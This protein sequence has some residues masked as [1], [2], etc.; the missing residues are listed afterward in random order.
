MLVTVGLL[1]TRV[2]RARR[3]AQP[4]HI[5]E[6]LGGAPDWQQLVLRQ[7]HCVRLDRGAVLHR[8]GRTVGKPA[9]MHLAAGTARFEHP[10]LDHLVADSRQIEHLP[11]FGSLRRQIS[12][13]GA[14]AL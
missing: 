6:Q 5:G 9:A 13:E 2:H 7:V 3:Q 12:Y 4:V 8:I 10:V 14:A 1:D 11:P